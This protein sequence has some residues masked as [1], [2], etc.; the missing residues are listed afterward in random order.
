[1]INDVLALGVEDTIAGHGV[2]EDA[3]LGDL[4]GLEALVLL[5]V[6]SI[7]VTE[8]VVADAAGKAQAASDQEVAHDGF[9]AR[10]ARFEV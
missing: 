9:K 2:I 4:L 6:L 8:M 1:M 7:I 10:L 3:C 5:Q